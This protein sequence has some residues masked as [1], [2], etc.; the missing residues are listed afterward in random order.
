[1]HG[2]AWCSHPKNPTESRRFSMTAVINEVRRRGK[3]LRAI[4]A[5]GAV[6]A[7]FM[8][9]ASTVREA[10]AGWPWLAKCA[11]CGHRGC[12]TNHSVQPEGW[13]GQWYWVRSPDQEQ[14]VVMGLYNRYCIRC[15]GVDGRGVW[16]IPDVPDFTDPRWQSSRNDHQLVNILME[17]RGAVMPMFRGTLSLDEACA[18]ARYLRTFVPGTEVPRVDVGRSGS[19]ARA[20]S[21][22]QPASAAASRPAEG[23]RASAAATSAGAPL[24][25]R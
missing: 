24:V 13:A 11:T 7:V 9:A 23:T 4:V 19:A 1:M 14:R 6:L 2:D 25:A 12:H 20:G 3:R 16:D 18:M 17:G 15:H 5:L 8:A 21:N 22:R 10:S